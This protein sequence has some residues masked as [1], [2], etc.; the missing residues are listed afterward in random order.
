MSSKGC[1][2]KR[3]HLFLLDHGGDLDLSFEYT[4]S[5]NSIVVVQSARQTAHQSPSTR[6]AW[7]ERRRGSSSGEPQKQVEESGNCQHK[8][9]AMD[10]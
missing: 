7:E 6:E 9:A 5:D 1:E 3:A 2:R 4:D 10:K 8:P